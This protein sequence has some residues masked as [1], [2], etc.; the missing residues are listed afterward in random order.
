MSEKRS[1]G[2]TGKPSWRK[3][4]KR[5][6]AT[7]LSIYP[8]RDERAAM[9]GGLGDAAG[10]CDAIAKN[11]PEKEAAIARLCGDAI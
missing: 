1:T 7:A 10:L 8:S 11:L 2:T 9:R 3:A 5:I 4:E 6:L